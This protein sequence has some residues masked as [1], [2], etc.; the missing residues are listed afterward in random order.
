MILLFI[1]FVYS[2]AFTSKYIPDINVSKVSCSQVIHKLKYD[3]CYSY[4]RKT[5][6]LTAYD[7]TKQQLEGRIY[8]R[9]TYFKTDYSVP[10][11]YRSYNNNY[12]HEG[13]DKGH[14]C[15]NAAFNHNSKLQKQTF[16]TSNIA[17]Q[18]KWL[19]RRYWAKVE[20]FARYEAV[21]YG[22]VEVVTG[23]CGNQGYIKNKVVIPLWWFKIIYVPKLHKTIAFLAPNINKG[24]KTAN[25]KKYQSTE[26]QI[27]KVCNF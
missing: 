11:K 27:K 4:Q 1:I 20:R 5:P 21:K 2:G 26:K 8:K 9:P 17:P 3:I 18:A 23:S 24:M 15:P 16:V 22:K 7:I 12:A 13:Y 6:I 19:N 14:N 25:I 10:R